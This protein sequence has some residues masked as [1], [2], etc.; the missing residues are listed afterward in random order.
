MKHVMMATIIPLMDVLTHV[1]FNQA[2]IEA[3]NH[4][5]VVQFDKMVSKLLMK[6]VTM[7]MASIMMVALHNVQ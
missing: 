3:I 2:I 5:S 1:L 4:H 6:N 7:G